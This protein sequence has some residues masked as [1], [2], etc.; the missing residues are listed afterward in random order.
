M[1]GGITM[2]ESYPSDI[3]RTQFEIIRPILESTRKKTKPR[4]LDLYDIFC[5]ILYV[6][7][8][9]CQWRMLPKDFPKWQ[10]VY[11]YFRIWKE[12]KENK[13][14]GVFAESILEKVLKKNGHPN[15][16]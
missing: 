7:K 3:S 6:M 15:S 8:S 12:K 11:K 1:Y 5:A 2:R 14:S 10:I 13:D 4:T 9:G 16:Q